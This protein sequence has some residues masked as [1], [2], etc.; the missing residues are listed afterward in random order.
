MKSAILFLAALPGALHAQGFL[1]QSTYVIWGPNAHAIH[2]GQSIAQSFSP[3]TRAAEGG[4]LSAVDV[5]IA[6]GAERAGFVT[7]N[8]H[9]F[10]E[11]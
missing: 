2:S 8:I 11:V 5:V 3:N 10:P 4:Y 9:T 6:R 1:D 7:L